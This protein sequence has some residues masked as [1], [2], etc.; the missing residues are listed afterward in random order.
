MGIPVLLTKTGFPDENPVEQH[1]DPLAKEN[2][3]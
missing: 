1:L 3:A 2:G